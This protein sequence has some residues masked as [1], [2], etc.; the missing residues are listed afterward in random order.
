MKRSLVAAGKFLLVIFACIG[1]AFSGVFVAMKLGLTK[2]PG[3]IDTQ[4]D[5]WNTRAQK[6]RDALKFPITIKQTTTDFPLGPWVYSSEWLVLKEGIV[7]DKDAITRAAFVSGVT[8]RLIVAQIVSEQLRLFTSERQIFKDVF[9]PLRVLGTQTQF[10]LG[11]TGVKEETAKKIEEHLQDRTSP[12]YLGETY[13]HVMSYPAD[14]RERV[15]RFSNYSDHYYS[16][17]YT[18]LFLH[19][20]IMQ[21]KNAGFPIDDRPEVLATLFN[22]GFDLSKP[23]ALPQVGG[24]SIAIDGQQ[25]TFGGLAGEFYYSDELIDYFPR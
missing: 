1:F 12:F 6:I 9:Q 3:L 19:Q 21:W 15:A 10:S 25:Y 5:F 18:G 23:N 17:L 4:S 14:G 7:K 24:S 16:Y 11:V 20:I 8:P 13:E 22:I 2:T